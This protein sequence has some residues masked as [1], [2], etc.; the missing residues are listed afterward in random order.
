MSNDL[1][2]ALWYS[3]FY[4]RF[5][6]E[7][8]FLQPAGWQGIANSDLIYP[9]RAHSSWHFHQPVGEDVCCSTAASR[10]GACFYLSKLGE[11]SEHCVSSSSV[12]L[13]LLSA[14][15]CAEIVAAAGPQ[16]LRQVDS[17]MDFIAGLCSMCSKAV[18]EALFHLNLT[19][20]K[21][22]AKIMQCTTPTFPL[23]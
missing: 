17:V 21:P 5:T 18:H 9:T 10:A 3:V 14:R 4:F 8:C 16:W 7:W 19:V 12:L 15:F 2:T 11:Y 13:V 20:W 22:F 1:G 6:D 23:A